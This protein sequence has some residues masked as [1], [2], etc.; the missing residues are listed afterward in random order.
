MNLQQFSKKLIRKIRTLKD[1]WPY[2]SNKGLYH[3]LRNMG[4]S[5]ISLYERYKQSE[6]VHSKPFMLQ[7]EPTNLCNFKCTMCVR[8]KAGLNLGSMTYHNFIQILDKMNWGD[9]IDFI[10]LNSQELY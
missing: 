3:L 9:F 4:N 1:Q 8:D 7:I 6:R 2:L 10:M 5:T